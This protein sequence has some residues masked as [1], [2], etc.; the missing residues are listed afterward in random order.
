[1]GTVDREGHNGHLNVR[2]DTRRWER[3]IERRD[4][5]RREHE[6][7]YD[8]LDYHYTAIVNSTYVLNRRTCIEWPTT[9]QW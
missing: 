8:H 3:Y 6:H 9:S 7:Y 4:S 2:E 1:M 5:N